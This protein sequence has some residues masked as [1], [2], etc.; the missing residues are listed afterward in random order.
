MS[1]QVAK[2][3]AETEGQKH[4][5]DI[6]ASD[7]S[8]RDAFNQGQL[9]TMESVILVNG[10]EIK[11]NDA[12]T[13]QARSMVEQINAN[14]SKI[15]S[16]IDL[17]ISQAADVDDRIWWRHVR[18]ALDSFIEHGKLK[19]MEGQLK[20][21]QGQ[22]KASLLELA[23]KLPL[24]KSEEKRNQALSSFYQ[25]LGFKVSAEADRL[26]FDLMQDMNWDDFERTMNQI[27]AIL[28]DVAS[29]IPFAN[30]RASNSGKPKTRIETTS[31]DKTRKYVE[32]DYDD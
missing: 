10:S 16:E 5:N 13:S 6:L 19:A 20:V 27:H 2:T 12:Q 15:D 32:Y 14:I 23:G 4:T 21:S 11:L 7:A 30:P 8:F 31:R 25:Y 28:G 18:V 24:M 26:R 3:T 22:L 29:F 17:L 9:D 1:A